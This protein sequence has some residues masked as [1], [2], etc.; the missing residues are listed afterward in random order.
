MPIVIKTDEDEAIGIEE[1]VEYLHDAKIET[2]DHDSM[3]SAGF[4]LK[5]L[6]N[7]RNFLSQLAVDELKNRKNLGASSNRYGPQVIMLY[8]PRRRDQNFF[9]RAN[10]WPSTQDHIFRASG[11]EQFFYHHP[12]DHSFNFLTVG[13]LGPG[14]HSN[15]YE[16]DY[17]N[18]HG[19]PEEQVNLKFIENMSLDEGKVMLY[20]S[21][22]DIHDQLPPDSMSISLNIMELSIRGGAIDQYSFDTD[23]SCVSSMINRMPMAC[24]MPLI[25]A[26][27]DDNGHDYLTETSR[28]HMSGRV[29]LSAIRAM[30][31]A[32]QNLDACRNV[33]ALGLSNDDGLVSG[34]AATQLRRLEILDGAA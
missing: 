15:Y 11:P 26:S 12:H 25:A 14:Y 5:R 10:F 20:R 6:A 24:L 23:K 13:Y 1:L 31:A 7:N 32:E 18:T 33:L 8:A 4:M 22:I 2:A 9:M 17:S 3:V 19:Y 34:W 28:T 21:C 29:R 16:Y 30:A 27:S